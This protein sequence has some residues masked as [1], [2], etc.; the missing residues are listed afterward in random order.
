MCGVGILPH[1][2]WP[3]Q[4]QRFNVARVLAGLARKRCG[5]KAFPLY[6]LQPVYTLGMLYTECGRGLKR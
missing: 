2:H 1:I 3:L 4:L 6:A 5:E